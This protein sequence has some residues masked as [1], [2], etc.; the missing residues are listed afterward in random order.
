MSNWQK[1]QLN[2]DV[3]KQRTSIYTQCKCLIKTKWN[4]MV[5]KVWLKVG[6]NCKETNLQTVGE[7]LEPW[8]L[9]SFAKLEFKIETANE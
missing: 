2:T 7:K 4:Y 6:L 5:I 8:I 1:V 3:L 9:R